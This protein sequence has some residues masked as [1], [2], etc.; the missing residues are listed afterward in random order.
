MVCLLDDESYPEIFY[1]YFPFPMAWSK[2]KKMVHFTMYR[3]LNTLIFTP[4]CNVYNRCELKLRK[5]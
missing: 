1:A 3:N 4:S 2:E 5:I